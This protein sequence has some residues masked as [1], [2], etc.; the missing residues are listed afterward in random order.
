LR[1][2]QGKDTPATPSSFPYFSACPPRRRA[3][4]ADPIAFFLLC[5]GAGDWPLSRCGPPPPVLMEA[6]LSWS[7]FCGVE[8]LLIA[9]GFLLNVDGASKGNP[10]TCGGGGCIRDR[11]GNLKLAFAHNYGFGG[12]LV[13]ER[14]GTWRTYWKGVHLCRPR[15][16]A[17]RVPLPDYAGCLGNRVRLPNYASC[18]DNRVCLPNYA[19]CPS[20]KVL[21]LPS[22]VIFS[23][24]ITTRGR[25]P[26]SSGGGGGSAT[27]TPAMLD[28]WCHELERA[29]TFR[30]LFVKTHKRKGTDD[31]VS[32][33]ARTI[34]VKT[35]DRMMADRYA[36][37]TPQPDLDPEAWVRAAGGPR[38]S[39][40]YDFGDSLDTTP[41]LSSYA[42]SVAPP[43]YVSS[44]ATTPDN[45][46]EDMRILI[47][48]ELQLHFGAMVEQLISV[49]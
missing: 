37:G 17:D 20:D 23:I 22:R 42:S 28:F 32:E 19:G 2:R 46:G 11:S 15:V 13:A 12:S 21:L 9:E 26:S 6:V 43:A 38:K 35:Y 18:P 41:A 29:P 34:T 8:G 25:E 31:Y 48:E 5:S 4:P 14:Y 10:G 16:Y 30:K 39:R 45:G 49:I 44:S 47:R 24:P 1:R 36:E 7:T 3:S 27:W 40:V 33:I